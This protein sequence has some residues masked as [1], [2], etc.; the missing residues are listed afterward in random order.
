M[1]HFDWFNHGGI[2][3]DIELIRLPAHYLKH[4]VG[5]SGAPPW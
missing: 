1:R 2:Y 4:A 5:S 3:R